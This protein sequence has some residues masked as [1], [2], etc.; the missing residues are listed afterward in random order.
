MGRG[1]YSGRIRWQQSGVLL[2]ILEACR[3]GA[4]DTE[5]KPCYRMQRAIWQV[6]HS[7]RRYIWAPAQEREQIYRERGCEETHEPRG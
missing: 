3:W 7:S 1:R 4:K 2:R 5:F 6:W